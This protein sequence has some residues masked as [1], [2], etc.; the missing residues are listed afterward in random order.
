MP[1][2]TPPPYAVRKALR[3]QTLAI[4]RAQSVHVTTAANERIFYTA[5]DAAR[6]A[7]SARTNTPPA[8]GNR[9][10]GKC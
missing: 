5:H 10:R 2:L 4:G 3:E 8:R 6:A 7:A 9:S 1:T